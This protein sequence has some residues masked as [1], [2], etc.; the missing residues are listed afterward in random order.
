MMFIY[1]NV[2]ICGNSQVGVYSILLNGG[3][4]GNIDN[5]WCFVYSG[6]G[7]KSIDVV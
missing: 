6:T 1:N 3:N 5:G 4:G 2:G 7:G